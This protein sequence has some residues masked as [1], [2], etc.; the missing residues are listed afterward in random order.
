[1]TEPGDWIEPPELLAARLVLS[2]SVAV[3]V[4]LGIAGLATGSPLDAAFLGITVLLV[5][6][7][8]WMRLDRPSSIRFAALAARVSA[9]AWLWLLLKI[10]SPGNVVVAWVWFAVAFCLWTAQTLLRTAIP[11]EAAHDDRPGAAAP[12]S[13]GPEAEGWIDEV[14]V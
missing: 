10:E 9:L 5:A 11:D 14:A 3:S 7:A 6:A 4:L 2:T 12:E 1:M 13:R 8:S